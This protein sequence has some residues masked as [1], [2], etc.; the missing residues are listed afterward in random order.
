MQ[1]VQR[2]IC[3]AAAIAV[4][5]LALASGAGAATVAVNHT[6]D[7][8]LAGLS[9]V[10]FTGVQG[11]PAFDEVAPVALGV[12]DTLHLTIDFKGSQSLTLTNTSMLWAFAY[13]DVG[14]RVVGT[15]QLSLLDSQGVAFLTSNW[16]TDSEGDFHFG[17][18]FNATDFGGG[19]PGTLTFSGLRYV[20]TVDAY[21][22]PGVTSRNYSMPAFYY[23]ANTTVL[24][25]P[26]PGTVALMLAG[27]AGLAAGTRRKTRH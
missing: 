4:A 13:A 11:P 14:S 3:R 1:P 2:A 5:S 10:G 15:G 12:G 23:A 21:E 27:L 26:E 7:L 9:P 24:A 8:T 18:S 25:V 16:K 22:A 6:L 17:Q 20:G 19:L